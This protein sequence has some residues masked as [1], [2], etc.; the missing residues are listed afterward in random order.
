MKSNAYKL[1][2]LFN[3]VTSKYRETKYR[4]KSEG[5]VLK[6]EEIIYFLN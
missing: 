6:V 3:H 5:K 2:K 1:F 4:S